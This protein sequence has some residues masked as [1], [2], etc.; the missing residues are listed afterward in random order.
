V[1]AAAVAVRFR[2]DRQHCDPD[3]SWIENFRV[4]VVCLSLPRLAQ[5]PFEREI[6]SSG[7]LRSRG[8]A[9]RRH[10]RWAAAISHLAA[11]FAAAG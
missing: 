6:L 9:S 3:H 1:Q 4:L 8:N 7:S 2:G 5:D 10:V 11:G